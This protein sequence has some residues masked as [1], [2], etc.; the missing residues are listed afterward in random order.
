MNKIININTNNF[1]SFR[2]PSKILKL[3]SQKNNYI[4]TKDK[5]KI[6]NKQGQNKNQCQQRKKE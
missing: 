3:K 2:H 5:Y 1:P 6:N 4:Y